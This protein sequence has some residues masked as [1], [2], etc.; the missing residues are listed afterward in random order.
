V[1]QLSPKIAGNTTPL[2]VKGSVA[3][4]APGAIDVVVV[5]AV[6]V[7]PSGPTGTVVVGASVTV[8]GDTE[9]DVVVELAVVVGAAVTVV[10]ETLVDV[11]TVV[12]GGAAVVVGAGA[13]VVVGATVVVGAVVV[14]GQF[15][16]GGSDAE[17]VESK[18]RSLFRIVSVT[19]PLE[20]AAP[21][22]CQICCGT[23][24]LVVS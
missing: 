17:S 20:G 13:V 18:V 4:T 21:V 24:S 5:A 19:V 14:V 10:P 16:D 12:V 15:S 22:A 9:I 1:R 7:L 8:V 3:L 23:L 6:L 2:P 11:A